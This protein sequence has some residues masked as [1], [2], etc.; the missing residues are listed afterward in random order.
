MLSYCLL[1]NARSHHVDNINYHDTLSQETRVT[2]NQAVNSLVTEQ[3]IRWSP[4]TITTQLKA[5]GRLARR[6]IM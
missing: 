6:L 1:D 4:G 3:N 5:G 2:Q